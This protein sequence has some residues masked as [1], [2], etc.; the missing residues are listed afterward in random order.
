MK[1]PFLRGSRSPLHF[2][3][4]PLSSQRRWSEAA[5]GDV[6]AGVAC[7]NSG[8][9]TMRR[10][11]MPWDCARAETG[12]TWHNRIG[13]SATGKLGIPIVHSDRSRSNTPGECNNI[14]IFN[15]NKESNQ[16]ALTKISEYISVLHT[17]VEIRISQYEG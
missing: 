2:P 15:Y 16:L 13:Q 14:Y 9:S 8:D 7:R 10:W 3:L 1:S 12:P 11:S 4:F 5:A 6:G 17:Y